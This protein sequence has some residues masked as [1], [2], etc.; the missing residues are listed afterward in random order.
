VGTVTAT[1]GVVS[2]SDIIIYNQWCKL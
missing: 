2:H 1:H